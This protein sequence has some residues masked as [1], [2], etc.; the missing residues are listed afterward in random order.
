MVIYVGKKIVGKK[1]SYADHSGALSH[2]S[3]VADRN[4]LIP[5]HIKTAMTTYN[6]GENYKT[7]VKPMLRQTPIVPTDPNILKQLPTSDR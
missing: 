7:R 5:L 2:I 1:V 3:T 6:T 4:L